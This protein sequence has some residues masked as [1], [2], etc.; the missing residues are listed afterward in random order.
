MVVY[1]ALRSTR[2][3]CRVVH[4]KDLL[5]IDT[6]PLLT[7]CQQL[8]SLK[9]LLLCLVLMVEH[10]VFGFGQC[11]EFGLTQHEMRM[12]GHFLTIQ[13]ICTPCSRLIIM[14]IARE[15]RAKS[16]IPITTIHGSLLLVIKLLSLGAV[17]LMLILMLL[18]DYL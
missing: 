17:L 18:L 2:R 12:R 5:D 4:F 14:C 16:L 11:R 7:S 10:V 13:I 6:R 1:W 9:A 8:D 3:G 15:R